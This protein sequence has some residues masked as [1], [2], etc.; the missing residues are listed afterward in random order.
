MRYTLVVLGK[1]EEA[2][3]LLRKG[4]VSE[5]HSG[6]ACIGTATLGR[7][8]ARSSHHETV[9]TLREALG[10]C[11]YRSE[12]PEIFQV[13]N[14]LMTIGEY[15]LAMQGYEDVL[16]RDSA[17]IPSRLSLGWC[18]YKLGDC[19]RAAHHFLYA[20]SFSPNSIAAFKRALLILV[21]GDLQEA[22]RHYSIALD[23]YGSEVARRVG[24]IADLQDAPVGPAV[25]ARFIQLLDQYISGSIH[26]GEPKLRHPYGRHEVVHTRE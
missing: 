9:A 20:D 24:A 18:F 15:T 10:V 26:E 7:S 12:A 21:T 8:L 4:L 1:H 25:R 14:E 5:R 3:S 13:A 2:Q 6:L 19:E 16:R 17:H 22:A 23:T 11:D